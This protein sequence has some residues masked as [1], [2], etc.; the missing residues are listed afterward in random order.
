MANSLQIPPEIKYVWVLASADAVKIKVKQCFRDLFKKTNQGPAVKDTVSTR[1]PS[2]K[3]GG[4]KV[5]QEQEDAKP[6]A[7]R[8]RSIAPPDSGAPAM[9]Q[10]RPTSINLIPMQEQRRLPGIPAA[11]LWNEQLQMTGIQQSW[12]SQTHHRAGA[13]N[14]Y[15]SLPVPGLSSHIPTFGGIH[16]TSD[17]GASFR[18]NSRAAGA[19]SFERS[20]LALR[21]LLLARLGAGDTH[22]E[23]PTASQLLLQQLSHLQQVQQRTTA[24]APA[25]SC[26]DSVVVDLLRLQQSQGRQQQMQQQSL[27]PMLAASDRNRL[28]S[29]QQQQQEQEHQQYHNQ[30]VLSVEVLLGRQR[31]ERGEPLPL[32]ASSSLGLADLS[33]FF[34]RV[35]ISAASAFDPRMAQDRLAGI[36]MLQSLQ[37]SRLLVQQI[38]Q[39]QQQRHGG[40]RDYVVEASRPL[41][42]RAIARPSFG[43]YV[44]PLE[45]ANEKEQLN[46]AGANSVNI[47]FLL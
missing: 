31:P 37:E 16:Q 30:Q 12:E 20:R 14:S 27:H 47:R 9:P 25:S 29:E 22:Q 6:K 34:S 36:E 33:Q 26:F 15:L 3:S 32:T 17:I 41:P 1:S 43:E 40:S 46:E 7:K 10:S 13:V 42:E 38:R 35:P 19:D 28:S 24:P 4:G 45:E 44:I 5:S 2:W 21:N 39:Q 8:A 11:S 23:D 18:S